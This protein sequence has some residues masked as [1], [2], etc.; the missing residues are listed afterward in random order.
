[1]KAGLKV[2]VPLSCGQGCMSPGRWASV[3]AWPKGRGRDASGAGNPVCQSGL[4]V[5]DMSP[6][7]CNENAGGDWDVRRQEIQF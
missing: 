3:G 4:T 1:M 7:F 6:S 2:Y 5:E